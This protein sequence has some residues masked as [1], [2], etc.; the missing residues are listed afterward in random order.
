MQLKS[1]LRLAISTARNNGIYLS[2]VA[3][4]PSTIFSYGMIAPD[5]NLFCENI[6]VE[7]I[8][9]PYAMMGFES[10][11]VALNLALMLKAAARE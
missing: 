4:K 8:G 3:T 10:Y 11:A 1:G 2:T 9:C 5:V 7:K 6:H